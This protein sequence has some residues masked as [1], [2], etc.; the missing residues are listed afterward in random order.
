MRLNSIL[1]SLPE[2]STISVICHAEFMSAK[3]SSTDF[4]IVSSAAAICHVHHV[5]VV[6]SVL[7]SLN[8]FSL[9]QN[10]MRYCRYQ[11]RLHC[12]GIA[13]FNT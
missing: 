9:I 10:D 4:N 2:P 13:A 6:C 3:G 1:S 5:H 7:V 11:I 8:N 12:I